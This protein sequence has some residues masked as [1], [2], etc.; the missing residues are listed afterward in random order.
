VTKAHRD[1]AAGCVAQKDGASALR[2]LAAM[3][4][5]GP[6]D[7]SALPAFGP[8]FEQIAPKPEDNRSFEQIEKRSAAVSPRV[9]RAYLDNLSGV[10]YA[11]AV[12]E[13]RAYPSRPHALQVI[14]AQA[15]CN[16]AT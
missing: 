7:G 11:R 3:L 8:S 10:D 16:M 4:Q 2:C 9:V 12:V 6:D 5:A 1:W 14:M 13:L 15:K